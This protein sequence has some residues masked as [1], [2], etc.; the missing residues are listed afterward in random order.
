MF[1][2]LR[3]RITPSVLLA[4]GGAG[5]IVSVAS[6][7]LGGGFAAQ[8]EAAPSA[9]SPDEWRSFKLVARAPITHNTSHFRFA[10][11]DSNQ[12]VGLPVASCLLTRA[13]IGSEKPNGSRAY[14]I[15]PYTPTSLPDARGHFDLVVKA[16]PQGKMSKHIDDLKVG[17]TLEC[18]GPIP[19]L[20]YKPNMKKQIGMIAG[21][22]GVTPMLQV[23]SEILRN[24]ADKT[25]V[26]LIFCNQSEQDIILRKE[27]DDMAKQH[28]NF[29][30]YYVIDKAHN[31]NWAGGLGYV[32]KEM[33]Q[34]HMPAPSDDN[35][36]MVCGP[37]PMYKALS[38]DK[39]PDKSQGELTGLLKD[40]GYTPSQ[41][42]KF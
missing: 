21:G 4:A 19:K 36:I 1:G 16:Y 34:Q 38:G 6:T 29:R 31:K 9:L 41:V 15:R 35:L 8:A 28:K 32:T 20:P 12:V 17:D 23:A 22:S 42:F 39:A 11:P 40:M 37:P 14:V 5:Y 25:D 26:S 33:V 7:W 18:K 13:P 2:A 27:I 10:L 3:S 30:V 24:P